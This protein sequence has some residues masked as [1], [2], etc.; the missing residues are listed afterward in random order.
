MATYGGAIQTAQNLSAAAAAAPEE[1]R[2]RRTANEDFLGSLQADIGKPGTYDLP[3]AAQ[4]NPTAPTTPPSAA[5]VPDGMLHQDG[6]NFANKTAVKKYNKLLKKG[7]SSDEAASQLGGDKVMADDSIFKMSKTGHGMAGY[8]G[9]K[10]GMMTISLDKDKAKAQVESSSMFRTVSRMQAEAEQLLAR[11]G[12]LYD[13]MIK[14]TQLP[15]IE[16]AAA[17]AR[18]NTENIRQAMARG[19]S[20]RRDAF[21]AIQKI[22]AQD[23]V[24][25]QKGQALAQ[26]HL[27][28]D[29]WSR[30]YA[31]SAT[32]FSQSW[33][34]NVAGVR[35]SY[36]SAMDNAME[37]F[38][39][40]SLPFMF[41]TAQKA[42]EWRE[43]QSAQSR[44]KVNRWITGVLGLAEGVMTAY[45]GGDA[46]GVNQQFANIGGAVASGAKSAASSVSSAASSLF[47]TGGPNASD[48][49]PGGQYGAPESMAGQAGQ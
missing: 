42:Q 31:Q 23:A 2:E 9:G 18:E 16:G 10:D 26:A 22:R 1:I 33:S 17:A 32:A 19:G 34:Q 3:P 8:T 35:E 45:R 12:P 14:S 24:N 27:Q 4:P 11:Q 44:G 15:I 28:L 29:Q 48:Y 36:Q 43:A 40:K 47:G 21:A 38:D 5:N 25:M 46:S 13:D 6:Y 41:D 7:Y 39:S 20:A 37:L 30:Q 49:A